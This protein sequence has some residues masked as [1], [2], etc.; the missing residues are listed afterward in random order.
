MIVQKL[1]SSDKK[2]LQQKGPYSKPAYKSYREL[3]HLD[4]PRKKMIS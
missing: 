3:L 1:F 2:T 4:R